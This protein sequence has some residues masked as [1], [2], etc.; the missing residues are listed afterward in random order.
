MTRY[1]EQE[2][3]R[4]RSLECD[5]QNRESQAQDVQTTILGVLTRAARRPER[6]GPRLP[7][8]WEAC[9]PSRVDPDAD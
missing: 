2:E 9:A 7:R 6:G 8:G 5:R 1:E 3:S 4:L